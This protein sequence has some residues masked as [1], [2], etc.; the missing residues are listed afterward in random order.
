MVVCEFYVEIPVDLVNTEIVGFGIEMVIDIQLDV[1]NTEV[2]AEVGIV[3]WACSDLRIDNH[4]DMVDTEA[5]VFCVQIRVD[6]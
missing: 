4:F 1:L 6:I 5:V 2:L 3:L